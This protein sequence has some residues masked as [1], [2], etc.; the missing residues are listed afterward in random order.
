MLCEGQGREQSMTTYLVKEDLE[1]H[2]YLGQLQKRH[3]ES[4]QRKPK[5]ELQQRSLPIAI[6]TKGTM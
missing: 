3:A 2:R 4:V 1:L 5:I 6:P